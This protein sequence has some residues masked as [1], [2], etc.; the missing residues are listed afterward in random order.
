MIC[1]CVYDKHRNKFI[2]ELENII[3]KDLSVEN[4]VK[5][6]NSHE[7][8]YKNE[9][10]RNLIEKQSISQLKKKIEFCSIDKKRNISDFS[11]S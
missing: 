3:K 7:Y 8:I 1:R 2:E 11:H 6:I 9:N 5:F 4:I 10:E